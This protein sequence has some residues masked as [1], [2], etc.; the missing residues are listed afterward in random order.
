MKRNIEEKMVQKR[1]RLVKTKIFLVRCQL[2]HTVGFSKFFFCFF[3]LRVDEMP[4]K[5]QGNKEK[6]RRSS[7]ASF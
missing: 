6:L 2:P 4:E 3:V 7:F 1:V 5:H